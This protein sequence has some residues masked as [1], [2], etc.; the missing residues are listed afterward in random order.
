MVA[1]VGN[2]LAVSDD[3]VKLRV[4]IVPGESMPS[5]TI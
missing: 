2:V 1:L 3:V 4:L 5:V